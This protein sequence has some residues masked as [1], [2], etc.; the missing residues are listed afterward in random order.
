MLKKKFSELPKIM[1][2]EGC[3]HHGSRKEVFT[4][5]PF[6]QKREVLEEVEPLLGDRQTHMSIRSKGQKEILVH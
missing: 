1:K 2:L 6:V 3:V 4:V 5:S